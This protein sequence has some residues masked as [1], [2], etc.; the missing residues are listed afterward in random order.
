MNIHNKKIVSIIEFK[1]GKLLSASLDKFIK[2]SEINYSNN[3]YQEI[4]RYDYHHE[5]INY[6]IELSSRSIIS[7][8]DSKFILWN[9][10]IKT[11]D[12]LKENDG[13]KVRKIIQLKNRKIIMNHCDFFTI[14]EEKNSILIKYEQ[15]FYYKSNPILLYEIKDN[16]YIIG[17]NEEFKIMDG[18]NQN[19]F[20]EIN[21]IKF[22]IT[23]CLSIENKTL[24]AY[25]EN[26][27]YKFNIENLKKIKK[28]KQYQI[29]DYQINN[30]I[31][32]SNK[33]IIICGDDKKIKIFGEN[34]F[35]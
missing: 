5:E 19:Y 31:Q 11:K 35:C 1:N 3:S 15:T 13:N 32:L 7:T 2:I 16:I 8:S 21:K 17:N 12:Y 18:N 10:V 25:Y 4:E 14:W 26:N 20:T 9:K 24:L 29:H 27:I 34:K 6:V 22:K 23:N 30:I 28:E 33:L